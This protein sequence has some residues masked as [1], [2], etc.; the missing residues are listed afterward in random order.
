M[1]HLMVTRVEVDEAPP[2]ALA[3]LDDM[4]EGAAVVGARSECGPRHQIFV[5][6]RVAARPD[7]APG[8]RQRVGEPLSGAQPPERHAL[9][10]QTLAEAGHQRD[11]TQQE[12]R[13]ADQPAGN[14]RSVVVSLVHV[15]CLRMGRRVRNPIMFCALRW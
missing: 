2:E 6:S 7:D 10:G 11:R 8:A 14:L 15:F 4:L 3:A 13:I 5:G 1:Q 9:P 12:P